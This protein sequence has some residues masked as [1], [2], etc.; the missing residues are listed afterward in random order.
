MK[1]ET[2]LIHAGG[3]VDPATGAVAPPIHL[4]TTFE[5]GA[6]V[7]QHEGHVD[8]RDSNPTQSRLEAALAAIEGGEAAL[9]FGSGMAAAAA[10]GRSPSPRASSCSPTPPAWA[11]SRA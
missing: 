11:A 10:T 7:A 9:V 8:V 2:L 4:S 3:E 5:H 1:L 6:D